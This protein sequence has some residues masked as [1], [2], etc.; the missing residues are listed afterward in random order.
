VDWSTSMPRS[1]E[2]DE[3]SAPTGLPPAV[4]RDIGQ[5]LRSLP[6][7]ANGF[8]SAHRLLL[9]TTL[10]LAETDL[11]ARLVDE[12]LAFAERSGAWEPSAVLL[13]PARTPNAPA[14]SPGPYRDER[15]LMTTA[16]ACAALVGWLHTVVNGG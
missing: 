16:V 11:G 7:P 8:E 13:V 5:W 10:D 6:T 3:F 14:T 4:G 2:V 12:L 15:G 1:R 9:A